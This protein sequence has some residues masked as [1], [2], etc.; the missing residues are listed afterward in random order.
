MFNGGRN[1]AAS[2]LRDV[3]A[4]C[5]RGRMEKAL[6][7]QYVKPNAWGAI[8][9][10]LCFFM[11]TPLTSVCI[12]SDQE[13]LQLTRRDK[14]FGVHFIDDKTGW[15]VGDNGLAL[16]TADGGESWQ[17]KTIPEG[18]FNDIFFVGEKG[19]IV[20]GGGLILYTDDGGKSWNKRSSNAS[21]AS[22][23]PMKAEMTM[24]GTC[25]VV[26]QPSVS[27]MRVLFL[28]KD[29]GFTVG[30]DGTILKTVNGGS[31]WENVS[32]DWMEL[33]PIEMMEQGIVSINLYDIFF[34][35]ETC[36]W[37]VG[38][39]AAVLY[40]SDG[41]KEWSLLHIA[42][43]PPLFSIYFKNDR[44][45]LAVG[46]NGF[47]LKTDDGGV[48]WE[49]VTIEPENSMYKVRI[50]N[51]HGIIVGDQATILKTNDGGKTWAKIATSLRPPYP[52]LSDAW[53]L[54]SPDSIQA[55]CVGKGVILKTGIL[56]KK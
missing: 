50:Y 46:Q 15:I 54:P 38:D 41:G 13:D 29:K 32:P 53:I 30:A 6:K 2:A 48:S 27:L 25:P 35:N 8:L 14:A 9:L 24:D 43:L 34:L 42:P 18:T 44:E 28:D 36:G 10:L 56:S 37:I 51:D 45:G 55:L 22:Q 17:R 1:R 5:S 7:K 49:K 31:S 3:R 40:T 26:E 21:G 47:S 23:T 12:A 39:S 16:M 4:Y 33:L 52:W 11:A 20:G 19:W